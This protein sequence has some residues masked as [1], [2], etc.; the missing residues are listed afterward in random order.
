MTFQEL[1]IRSADA[2]PPVKQSRRK[3]LFQ[4]VDREVHGSHK[5]SAKQTLLFVTLVSSS[6]WMGIIVLVQAVIG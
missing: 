4:R 6:L 1:S 3:R 5:W 2:L